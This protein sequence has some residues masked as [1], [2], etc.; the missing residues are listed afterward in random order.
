MDVVE[1]IIS[2][3]EIRKI[4]NR[5][6]LANVVSYVMILGVKKAIKTTNEELSN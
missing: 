4:F 2:K 5:I 3:K 6:I 1:I